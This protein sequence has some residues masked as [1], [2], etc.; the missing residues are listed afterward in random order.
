M[1]NDARLTFE[2]ALPVWL[3][4]HVRLLHYNTASCGFGVAYG[5]TKLQLQL[6]RGA[7]VFVFE[8]RRQS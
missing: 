4:R 2:V 5:H 3:T 1:A 6:W 8:R 7:W